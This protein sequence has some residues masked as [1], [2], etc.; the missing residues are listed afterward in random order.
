MTSGKDSL[1]FGQYLQALRLEKKISL[2]RVSEETRIGLGIL[3]LIEKEDHEK[4]PAEVFVKGF[5]RAYARTIDADGGEAVR[6]Y[7]SRL[8]VVHKLESSK[9]ESGALAARWWWNLVLVVVLFLALI[10][11]SLFGLAYIK[12]YSAGQGLLE[13]QPIGER[14]PVTTS[15]SSEDS[16][17]EKESENPYADKYV[18]RIDAQEDTWMKII[19]DN[20]NSREYKLEPGDHLVLEASSHFNLLIG[21]A[22]GVKIKLNDKAVTV[23]GKSGEIVNLNLP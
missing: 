18:L 1:S 21:N 2:E 5:L 4:L 20:E 6:R 14:I 3:Q 10:F 15:Q 9:T 22:A 8:E 11:A 19:I 23:L 13:K 17:A 16:A 12:E 7:E